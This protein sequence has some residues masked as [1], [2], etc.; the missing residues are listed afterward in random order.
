MAKI[1]GHPITDDSALGGAVIERSLRFRQTSQDANSPNIERTYASAGN[2]KVY[3]FSFWIK[4]HHL[5]FET[6]FKSYTA[7]SDRAQIDLQSDGRIRYWQVDYT[8][9]TYYV[10]PNRLL[11]DTNAWYHIV[12]AV[13]TTQATA[14][15]RVKFY[16]NGNLETNFNN[17]TYPPQNDSTYFNNNW[18]HTIG[19]DD[20]GNDF[21]IAEIHF[22]DGYQ[23]EATEFGYTEFQ[24]GIWRPKKYT[25]TYGNGNHNGYY[26]DFSDGTSLTTLGLDRSGRGNH[27]TAENF[28]VSAG[29]N[30][31]TLFDTPTKEYATLNFLHHNV[32]NSTLKN[33]NLYATIPAATSSGQAHGNVPLKSGK[34]YYEVLYNQ[35]GGNGDYLYVGFSNPAADDNRFYRAVRGSDGEKYPNTGATEVRFTTNDIIN[36]AVDLDAGKWYIGRNGTYWYSGDPVA[37]TGFVHSDLISAH[38]ATTTDGL[39]PYFYNATSGAGQEFS[40]NFGQRPFSYTP[41]SGF[42][43]INSHNIPITVSGERVLAPK[44]NFDVIY[45]TG[46][47]TSSLYNV[48]GLEFSPDL[49]IAKSRNDTIGHIFIDTVR[50]NDKQIETPDNSAEVTRGTP[51]Y[52]FLKDGFAV[53][54]GG[55]LNNPVNYVASCWKAGGAAVSN[56]DGTITSQVSVNKKAGFSIVTYTG[57]GTSGK[58]VGHGL[59]VTPVISI[60]KARNTTLDWF[61]HHTLVDGSM[62]YLRLNTTATNSNSSLSAF[63]STTLPVDDN[64]NQYVSYC[65]H[66][67]PGYSKFGTYTGNDNDDGPYIDLGFSP[68]WVMVKCTSNSEH[69]NIPVFT[70]DERSNGT[71]KFISPN[72]TTAERNMDDNPGIDFLSNGFKIRTSDGNMSRDNGGQNFIYMAF[73][74]QPGLTPYNITT[75]AR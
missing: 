44:K 16:I 59:D 64:T 45:Y 60:R 4:R 41:P 57:D 35:A 8:G 74:E 33:G 75:N 28:Q 10:Q 29:Y 38:P 34:W 65:W 21:Y 19:V 20:G 22:V 49:V 36:V 32:R 2:R 67:V 56:T 14:A 42:K 72:L 1:T 27:W 63:T 54:T 31:D 26:L 70:Y 40:V 66:D 43:E 48:T 39:I 11:R 5:N 46:Q 53:S 15:N 52:R 50:G 13:D 25:G 71:V 51:S 61:V 73:A 3:T 9:G 62:D 24:T 68:A 37:G 6:V 18:K 47:N 7:S 55:N 12:I 30:Q 23:K 17:A 58:T 69:W